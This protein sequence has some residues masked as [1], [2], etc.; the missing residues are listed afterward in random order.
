M[1]F[2]KECHLVPQYFKCFFSAKISL[3]SALKKTVKLANWCTN[4]CT[5]TNSYTD[6]TV[7]FQNFTEIMSN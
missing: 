1:I 3:V 6:K 5:F 2:L 4:V 7:L